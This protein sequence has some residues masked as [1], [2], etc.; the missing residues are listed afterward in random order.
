MVRYL[1]LVVVVCALASA[2]SAHA[3]L[4]YESNFEGD[5]LG[6]VPAGWEK[7]WDGATQASVI[8][9][10]VAAGNQVFASSD[11]AHDAS[12]HDVGGSIFAVGDA[13]WTDYVVQ[14]D[15]LYPTDFY[16]GTLFRYQDDTNFY[17]LDRRSAGELGTFTFYLH[18]GGWTG[19]GSGEFETQPMEWYRFRLSVQG[20]AFEAY[21]GLAADD[22]D[23]ANDVP[24]VSGSDASLAT[25][26]FALYGLIYIDNVVIGETSTDIAA[27]V[28]PHAKL[29]TTWASLRR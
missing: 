28:E 6:S 19:V 26:R 11:L 20:D 24:F 16:I 17:L 21:A 8:A 18:D 25:G 5:A 7:A 14:Y 9:D 1:L 15:A 3:K 10:P 27:A 22:P 2:G 12:R 13:G 4:L 29:A 23:F